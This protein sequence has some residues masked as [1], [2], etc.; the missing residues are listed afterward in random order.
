MQK[1]PAN[2]LV[3]IYW[4]SFAISLCIFGFG[5]YQALSHHVWTLMATGCA[6]LVA[7]LVTWPLAISLQESREANCDQFEKIMTPFT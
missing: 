3:W 1:R 4:I 7:T 5:L 2:S 6:C